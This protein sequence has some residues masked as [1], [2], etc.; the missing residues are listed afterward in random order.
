MLALLGG[1][2]SDAVKVDPTRCISVR[3]MRAECQR[4]VSNCTTGALRHCGNELTVEPELCIGC[5]TCAAVCPTS[6]IETT[7]LTD[8]ALTQAMRTSV[9]A[10]KGHPVFA[11]EKAVARYRESLDPAQLGP[12]ICRVTCLGRLDESALVGLAAYR[13]FDATLVCG[14][15]ETCPQAPGG[16]QVRT[17]AE[18]SQGLVSAFGSAMEIRITETMPER[19]LRKTEGRRLF[20]R[21][22]PTA[23]ATESAEAASSA[24]SRREL[25]SSAKGAVTSQAANLAA[26]SLGMVAEGQELSLRNRIGKIN[27]EGTLPQF[28]PSRR[29]RLYNYLS[30]IGAPVAETVVSHT[31]GTITIDTEKCRQCRMCA[32]FCP[33]GALR[34]LNATPTG[35]PDTEAGEYHHTAPNKLAADIPAEASG[36]YGLLHRPAA[37]VQC[38]ACEQICPDGAITV[39]ST[40]PLKEFMGKQAVVYRMKPPSWQPNKPDSMYMKIHEV[41][42]ADLE[43]CMF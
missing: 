12:E 17:I 31:I 18:S 24:V 15:C 10:T 14:N 27:A 30:H 36:E 26:E 33:T 38:R 7:S 23:T 28:V 16:H 11:C 41:L 1:I 5:G 37:C 19:C 6:A 35:R 3:H 20:R 29:T 4:C 34:R 39:S 32:T 9:K 43:M 2:E 8:E 42:G 22:R 13:S 21:E 40:V 25:F